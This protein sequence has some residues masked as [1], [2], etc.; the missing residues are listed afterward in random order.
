MLDH[1]IQSNLTVGRAIEKLSTAVIGVVSQA[2]TEDLLAVGFLS[3]LVFCVTMEFRRP[4]LQPALKNLKHSYWTNVST[5]I[6]NDLSL[7]LLSIPS[8][9]FIAQQFPDTGLLTLLPDGALKFLVS[10][11]LLDLALYAWHYATHRCDVLWRFHKV[12]HSDRCFNVTTG[13]RFHL[14]ELFFEVLIRVVFIAVMGVSAESVLINQTLISLFVL[15]HHT[16]VSFPQERFLARFL[17]VPSLHRMHHSA[18]REEHDSNYGAVLSVWDRLFGTIREG[19]PKAIGLNGVGEQ[20]F[21]DLVRYG[22]T[23]RV[24]FTRAAALAQPREQA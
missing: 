21:A 6:F 14:G 8:L 22:F 12:H 23:A 1:V 7:S 10:F 13:L 24:E 20:N 18:M 19:E 5:Y 11:L 16:N 15:F 4:L 2:R 9:Y 3:F 17:I